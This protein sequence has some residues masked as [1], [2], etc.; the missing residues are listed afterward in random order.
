MGELGEAVVPLEPRVATREELGLVHPGWFLDKL[1]AL[2][3]RG[4]G[5]IDEDTR[6][7]PASMEAAALAAGAGLTAIDAL[8]SGRGRA[9]GILRGP[10]AGTAVNNVEVVGFC[11]TPIA[12]PLRRSPTGASACWI[13]DYDAHHGNGTQ[14]VFYADP[15]VLFVSLH[16]WPL[17]PGT[18]RAIEMG[19][20]DGLGTTLNVPLPAGA[21]GDVYLARVRR[22][23]RPGGR[24]VR[25][26]VVVDLGRVRRPPCRS[27][28]RHGTE[29]RGL[30]G[31]DPPG[32]GDGAAPAHRR[33]ARRR[34]RPGRP[35]GQ[36]IGRCSVR[37]PVSTSARRLRPPAAPV[38]TPSHVLAPSG[39][40]SR[41]PTTRT[42]RVDRG[43]A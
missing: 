36:H 30:S 1:V 8:R 15:R 23:D 21:T 14:D 26:D 2:A 20:G 38:P 25:A 18:G 29:R 5:W 34:L 17:Y 27:A 40:R 31:T 35:Q 42:G 7:G 10:S 41:R 33:D 12:W 22:G 39:S 32:N 11:L 16:Q 28:H 24:A 37:W 9:G 6:M 43:R 3:E 19:T 13:I 4:G